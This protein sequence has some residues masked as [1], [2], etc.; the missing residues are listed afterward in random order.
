MGQGKKEEAEAVK[1]QVA[2]IGTEL[3]EK[4]QLETELE[5]KIR[6]HDEDSKLH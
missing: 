1:A 3:E 6:S 2:A 5:G 4:Q